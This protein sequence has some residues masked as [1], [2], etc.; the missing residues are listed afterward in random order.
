MFLNALPGESATKTAIRDALPPG[1]TAGAAADRDAGHGS[2]SHTDM[3][4]AAILDRLGWVHAATYRAQG[5]KAPYPDP[6][7]RPGVDPPAKRRVLSPEG[8]AYLQRL[9]D[10]HN[11][12]HGIDDSSGG[13]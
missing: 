11:A 6:W 7:P 4:L 13:G 8:F 12:R 5:A 3:L 10:E 9:R 1:Q 2:W